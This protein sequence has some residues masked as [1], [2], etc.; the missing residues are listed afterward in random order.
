MTKHK[1]NTSEEVSNEEREDALIYSASLLARQNG[2]SMNIQ[3]LIN[4]GI[5]KEL[6]DNFGIDKSTI[7]NIL[8]K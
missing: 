1:I 7:I 5:I 8:S 3:D 4:N 2:S 6:S